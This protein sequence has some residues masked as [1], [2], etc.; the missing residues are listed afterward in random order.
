MRVLIILLTMAM[1]LLL[2]DMEHRSELMEGENYCDKVREEYR[3]SCF[4]F[5]G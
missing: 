3:S 1:L 5:K 4:Y 2:I